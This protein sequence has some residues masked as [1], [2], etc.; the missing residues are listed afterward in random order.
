MVAVR[1]LHLAKG[2]P[3]DDR[4]PRL[5]IQGPDRFRVVRVSDD[6]HIVPG[7]G[8]NIAVLAQALPALAA[9][10]RA[11]NGSIL[12]VYNG[13]DALRL[14]GRDDYADFAQHPFG[15]AFVARDLFPGIA[16]IR[17]FEQAALFA[18]A[19]QRIRFTVRLPEGRVEDARVVGV[20]REIDGA[21]FLAAEQ[22]ALPVLATIIAAIDAAF[23]VR[24]VR[25]SQ[26]GYVHHVGVV[27][28]NA[29][30]RDVARIR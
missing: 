25:V 3:T 14:S 6:M 30:F 12:G 29:H 20:H 19:Q 4:F 27:R 28:R 5:H 18:A 15:Q 1:Y 24:P 9:I 17:R 8:A 16:A 21:R 10:I 11:E 13:P 23:R 22:D 7:T 2:A 26:R